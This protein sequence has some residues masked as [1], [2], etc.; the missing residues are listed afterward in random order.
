MNLK[1]HL[2]KVFKNFEIKHTGFQEGHSLANEEYAD[3]TSSEY[4]KTIYISITTLIILLFITIIVLFFIR[5]KLI[6][7][8][9]NIVSRRNRSQHGGTDRHCAPKCR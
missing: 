2:T 6:F 7:P 1:N 8:L 5:R 9:N 4:K 3:K